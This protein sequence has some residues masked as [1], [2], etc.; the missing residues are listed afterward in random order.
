MNSTRIVRSRRQPL[1][2]SLRFLAGILLTFAL[3]LFLFVIT[4]RPVLAEFREMTLLLGAT[5]GISLL[6]GLAAYYFGWF[7]RSP[8][9]AWTLLAGYLLS[10][11]LTWINVM[12]TTWRMFIEPHD[13]SLGTILMIFAT[14]IAVTLGYFVSM[15]V[16]DKVSAVREA[17]RA[18][19]GGHL[20]TRLQVSG[21]D[22]VTELAVAF[23]EMA[24]QLETA[25]Q[26][27]RELEQLRRN[28]IAWVGH[29]L[30]TPLASVQAM[31]EALAD[32]MVDDPATQ[33]RYLRTAKRDIH[34]LSLLIDNLFEMAQIDA[35]GLPL[36]RQRNSLR[37][38]LSDTLE[39]F[40]TLAAEKGVNLHGEVAPGIDPVWM[41]A[42]LIGRVLTNLLGNA[43]RHTPDGGHVYL[44]ARPVDEHRVA[45]AV[46][47]TGVGISQADL[48]HIFEQFYRGEKSR[49]RATG[50]AGLGLAITKSFV[51]AHGGDIGVTSN[52][53]QGTEF[54]FVL[55]RRAPPPQSAGNGGGYRHPLRRKEPLAG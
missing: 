47:D 33:E 43:I 11:L 4:M 41:D 50:G 1:Y 17:A 15:A 2:L 55:P 38:L 44:S 6:A 28:L 51:E 42:R 39:S 23:N 20:R 45:V 34:A 49:S 40:Q 21:R 19:A 3:T 14:S 53:G 32:G 37:D 5:A 13:R 27:R 36:D 30:R 9:L 48:P 54:T 16:T 12:V 18:I 35:G 24:D 29:D 7:E 52:P 25:A 8:R 46:R 10:S 22:E 31:V 26:R